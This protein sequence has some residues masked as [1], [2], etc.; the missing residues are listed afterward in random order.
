MHYVML[1]ENTK[2][3]NDLSEVCECGLFRQPSLLLKYLFKVTSVAVF[4]NEVEIVD[5][6]EHIIVFDDVL[7]GF[8]IGKDV[9]F[10]ISA[11][12]EFGILFEF[13]SF[14]HFNGDFLFVFNV[15][16]FEDSGVVSAA[17][18]VLQRIVFDHLA[19]LLHSNN[20]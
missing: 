14:D 4:V 17:D 10:V 18:F 16:G 3:L 6:F 9:D 15:D 1:V 7:R 11:F 12:F 19:H 20:Y 8:E 5:C 2:S 13:L